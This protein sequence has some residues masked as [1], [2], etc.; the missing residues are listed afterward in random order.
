MK[1][2]VVVLQ[3]AKTYFEKKTGMYAESDL[4]P[5]LDELRLLVSFMEDKVKKAHE[6]AASA[7]VRR[8]PVAPSLYSNNP[9]FV[10]SPE[11]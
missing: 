11:K 9:E 8:P 1:K 5:Y 6:A 3:N 2:K 4:Q 7:P 10:V